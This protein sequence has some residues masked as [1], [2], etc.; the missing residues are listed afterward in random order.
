MHP[1]RGDGLDIVLLVLAALY[2]FRGYR[3]GLIYSVLTA[4]G[5]LA[6][7]AAGSAL[8]P[9]LVRELLSRAARDSAAD[10]AVLQRALT[11]GI[12][13]LF[14]VLGELLAARLAR[15][16]RTAL[17]LT[18][19]GIVDGAGGAVLSTGAFL[20]VAWLIGTALGSAPYKQVVSQIRRSE[21]LSIVNAAVP[22]S[23]RA[24]FSTLLR[25]VQGKSFPPLFDPLGQLPQILDPVPAPDAGVVPA[26]LRAA[27]PSVVKIVGQAPEC[28]TQSEGSGFV[29]S[30]DH[31]LTN[32]HVVAGVRSLTVTTPGPGSRTLVGRVVLYDP[33]RD[34]AVIAVPGLGRPALAFAGTAVRGASAVVAG[35]PENGPF[36]AGAARISAHGA[37]TGP[38]IYQ[39]STVTR[40]VYTLRGRVEPGN[41]GGPL[42]TPDGK[43]YGVVFAKSTDQADVGYALSAAEV[44]G[45]VR[46]G[47]GA[48]ARVSTQGCD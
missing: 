28:S 40:D 11:V 35:Y 42:L 21:V 38:D 19:F 22:G 39:R 41:S 23:A 4:A 48:T 2:A 14:A 15:I 46:A 32:A 29:I 27:G 43:V 45:D 6:G 25:S 17:S 13:L 34:L 33:K 20:L 36:T 26:A 8:A 30:A 47:S 9:R 16:L 12:V 1:S 37:V 24:Q 7:A 3:R 5:F 31:V 10:R 44:E 18:P